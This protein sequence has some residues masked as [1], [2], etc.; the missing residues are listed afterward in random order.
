MKTKYPYF[1][2]S[3]VKFYCDDTEPKLYPENFTQYAPLSELESLKTSLDEAVK[4]CEGLI[5]ALEQI[6]DLTIK[7][8]YEMQIDQKIARNALALFGKECGK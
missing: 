6:A 8:E 1:A 7:R 5:G 2:N 4:R 3:L